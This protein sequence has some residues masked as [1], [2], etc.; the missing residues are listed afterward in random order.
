MPRSAAIVRKNTSCRKLIFSRTGQ[1]AAYVGRDR[2]I[3]IAPCW[4]GAADQARGKNRAPHF[5]TTGPT[6]RPRG[7]YASR[8]TAGQSAG[9]AAEDRGRLGVGH[10]RG[11]RSASRQ[12]YRTPYPDFSCPANMVATT[13]GGNLTSRTWIALARGDRRE[14]DITKPRQN[15]WN[16]TLGG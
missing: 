9:R 8:R 11:V 4:F 1:Y 15:G 7:G 13:R 12:A 14:T 6:G 3:I 10:A 2:A 16:V 5:V